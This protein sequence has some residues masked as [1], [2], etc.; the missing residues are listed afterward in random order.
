MQPSGKDSTCSLPGF[1][2]CWGESKIPKATARPTRKIHK[3]DQRKGLVALSSP[4]LCD[5]VDCSPARLPLSFSISQ[6]VGSQR[7]DLHPWQRS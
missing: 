1:N 4:T 5:P 6:S 3:T 2:P 7:E